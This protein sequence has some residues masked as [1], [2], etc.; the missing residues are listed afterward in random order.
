MHD[1]IREKLI[2][3]ARANDVIFYSDIAP[4]AGLDMSLPKDRD[5]IGEILDD[6]NHGEHA[7]G[8]PLLSAVVVLKKT[9]MP[10]Q[11]FFTM[12]REIGLF[13]GDDEDRFHRDELLKVHEYWKNHS[14]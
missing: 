12:S 14:Y 4:M 5:E 10:G 2:E 13:T 1:A 8:R 3:V 6:I 11:G 7:E 9:S